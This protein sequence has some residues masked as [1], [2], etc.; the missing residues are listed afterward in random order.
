MKKIDYTGLK[1]GE[2]AAECSIIANFALAIIKTVAGVLSGSIALLADAVHSFS[3]IFSSLAVY[4]GLK[5]SQ[6]KPDEKFPYGYYKFETL[7]SLIISVIIIISGFEIAMESLNGIITPKTINM[8]LIAITVAFISAVVSFLLTRLKDNVGREI[9]SPALINDGKHSFV[10]IF[11]SFIVFFGILTAYIGYPIFQ[12]VAGFAVAMLIIYIGIKSGKEALL[13]L[14]DA[15]LDS[16]VVEKIR[17]IAISFE[18]VKGIHNIK[19]RRSGP[20]IF[21][22]LHVETDINLSLQKASTISKSLEKRIKN[23]VNDLDSIITKIE[24]KKKFVVR[25]A[26][27]IDKDEGLNS[28]ISKHFGKAPYF[29]VVDVNNDNIKNIQLMK[30]PAVTFEQKKGLKTVKFL[31]NEEVNILLFNGKIKE[32]PS[33]ALSNELISVIIPHGE[34]LKNIILE[35]ALNYRLL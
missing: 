3:D 16:K 10:D 34:D 23:E 30:N 15:N 26:I 19:V 22:E 31:K 14:L 4:I 28:V 24:P 13:I 18:G 17:V 6:R 32:G 12:G 27:P 9:N 29:L 8:P 2:K 25:I 35:A 1:K 33:Y 20:Y 5:L 21:A 11:S 7:S